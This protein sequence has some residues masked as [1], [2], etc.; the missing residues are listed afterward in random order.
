MELRPLTIEGV[1]EIIPAVLKDDRGHF[2]ETYHLDK[3]RNQGITC[4]FS[5]DNQSFSYKGVVRGL[6]MQAPPFAQAKLVRV[7]VGRILDVV[8]DCR[9]NSP[10][11]GQHVSLELSADLNN[12]IFIPEGF[13]HGF[14]ALEDTILHY[15]CSNIFHKESERGINPLDATLNIDWGL[16]GQ[17]YILSEKDRQL[18]DFSNFRSPF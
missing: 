9:K 8:V 4:T 1:F 17:P 2:F 10:T 15:K 18:P 16:S 11:Y 3:L 12:S 6:H 13:A 7:I 5:Q 14:S